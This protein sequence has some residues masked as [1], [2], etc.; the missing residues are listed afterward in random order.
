[1]SLFEVPIAC[2]VHSRVA[3][4]TSLPARHSKMIRI[5][6]KDTYGFWAEFGHR[7]GGYGEAVGPWRA[8]LPVLTR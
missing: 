8:Y 7:S 6:E 2:V 5:L 4:A 3:P 1:M